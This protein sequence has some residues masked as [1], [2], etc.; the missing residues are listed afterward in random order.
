MV[1][2][3]YVAFFI[4]LFVFIVLTTLLAF[5]WPFSKKKGLEEETQKEILSDVKK[6]AFE[7]EL[8]KKGKV[9]SKGK[10]KREEKIKGKEV[11]RKEKVDVR[12]TEEIKKSEAESDVVKTERKSFFGLFKRRKFVFGN[13]G[14]KEGQVLKKDFGRKEEFVQHSMFQPSRLLTFRKSADDQIAELNDVLKK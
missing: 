6:L 5:S 12:K 2:A 9:V 13:E 8:D 10:I 11:A 1:I 7:K 14:R 4:V 3:S